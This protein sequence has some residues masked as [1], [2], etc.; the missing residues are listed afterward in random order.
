MND[1]YECVGGPLDGERITVPVEIHDTFFYDFNP[2]DPDEQDRVGHPRYQLRRGKDGVRR[3][4]HVD[5]TP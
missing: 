5:F 4:H 2:H 3:L 1:I